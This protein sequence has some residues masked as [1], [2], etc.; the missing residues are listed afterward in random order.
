MRHTTRTRVALPLAAAFAAAGALSA[1]SDD[2]AGPETGADVEDV[3]EEEPLEEEPLEE[4]LVEEEPLEEE[5]EAG[6]GFAEEAGALVGQTV[7]V[8]ATVTELVSENAMRIGEETSE[9][10]L[11]LTAGGTLSELGL[12]DPEAA[13]ENEA[14]VQVT[15]TV[16]RFDP[17][18]VEADYGIGYTAA[19]PIYEPYAGENVIIADS[20]TTITGEEVTVAGVVN[21]LVST[22]AFRLGGVGWDVLVLDAEQAAVAEGDAVEV[23]GTVRRFEIATIEEELG[24]DLDDALY[25][26]FEGQ[27]VL[28]ADSVSPATLPE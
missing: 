14:V 1:C 8:S 26:D 25:E 19:D 17:E 13:A 28:V 4:E 15:G 6:G 9:S 11:V 12:E 3:I 16:A 7:T 18:T 22:V 5:A 10:L 27:L 23:A 2:S 21:E 20:I 24:S